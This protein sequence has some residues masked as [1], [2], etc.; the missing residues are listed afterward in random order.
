M[1]R[2][3][4]FFV[5]LVA[6]SVNAF[7]SPSFLDNDVRSLS[8]LIS[9][10]ERYAQAL[11]MTVEQVSQQKLAH[12]KASDDLHQQLQSST[13]LSGIEKH[14]L[15]CS[16]RH[17]YGR[18]PFTCR[19]C[20][21]YLPVCICHQAGPKR[22]LPANLEV[23]VWTHHREWGLTSNTGSILARALEN[24]DMLMKG[25]PQHDIQL[26]EEIIGDDDKTLAVVLWPDLADSPATSIISLEQV[27]QALKQHRRV[28]LIAVD[29]TWSNAGRMVHRLPDTLPRLDLPADLV[30]SS[31]ETGS[32]L[33]PLRTR[34]GTSAREGSD[35]QVCTAEAVVA[36]LVALGLSKT[37][38][39]H[40]LELTKTKVDRIRR[41]R[42]MV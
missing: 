9:S 35:R 27:Q 34:Q 37:D 36:A 4:S 5:L 22:P 40:V 11:N 8:D 30:L 28:V 21:S 17:R 42:G 38:G 25:L 18:H 13:G 39:D 33:A 20:W 19:D 3:L 7:P 2:I 10:P 32:I 1:T 29:G 14:Q 24:C 15:L 12:Q 41:Y 26:Q 23:A 31:P 6:T 16:H